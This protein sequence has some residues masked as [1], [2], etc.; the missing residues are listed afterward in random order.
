MYGGYNVSG[1]IKRKELDMSKK[2]EYEGK[3]VSFNYGYFKEL[4]DLKAKEEN[5]RPI[6]I[7]KEIAT[8]LNWSIDESTN[9]IFRWYK[10]QNSP[11]DLSIIKDI[12]DFFGVD[13]NLLLVGDV[14]R[15]VKRMENNNI[16]LKKEPLKKVQQ[17]ELIRVKDAILDYVYDNFTS[18]FWNDYMCRELSYLDEEHNLSFRLLDGKHN[19]YSANDYFTTYEL[20]KIKNERELEKQTL[21]NKKKTVDVSLLDEY[22]TVVEYAPLYELFRKIE[23]ALSVLP[24]DLVNSIMRIVVNILPDE[25]QYLNELS[26]IGALSYGYN[27]FD[28]V[29]Q[30]NFTFDGD[31]DNPED[32]NLRKDSTYNIVMY[33]HKELNEL[34]NKYCD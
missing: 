8:H 6:W 1:Q 3:L 15:K 29:L 32:E 25:R 18:L 7:Y 31:F 17:D 19:Y 21:K 11:V 27:S 13:Y 22:R 12:A 20:D 28:D 10:G 33:V 2:Y 16:I 26:A 30:P 4:V 14:L 23:R 24:F 34:I 5:C 9:K